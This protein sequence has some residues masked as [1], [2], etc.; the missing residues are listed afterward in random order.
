MLF[1]SS[2]PEQSKKRKNKVKQ[3]IRFILSHFK[4]PIFPRTISS[5]NTM[6]DATQFKVAY[7]EEEML[8]TYEQSKFIDCRV[9]IYRSSYAQE[10]PEDQRIADLIIFNVYK[11]IFMRES[12]QIKALY[13]ILDAIKKILA[14]IP[15]ILQ[16]RSSFHIYQPIE[17]HPLEQ[18]KQFIDHIIR[19]YPE[20][21]LI[22]KFPGQIF[23]SR[24][25][26]LLIPGTF[27]SNIE[28]RKKEDEEIMLIRKWDGYRPRMVS[29]VLDFLS[30]PYVKYDHQADSKAFLICK[31]CFWCASNL[32]T[33]K[34]ITKC[35]M[36]VNNALLN[37]IPISDKEVYE[38][39]S[40]QRSRIKMEPAEYCANAST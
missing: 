40:S 6:Y 34:V 33:K 11:P 29:P 8:R 18:I 5:R 14:G 15:T 1:L 10:C 4:E 2:H 39:D 28:K 26:M 31:W 24:P 37:S 17:P 20:L 12:V 19:Q 16:S 35:P 32:S 30:R 36:C 25:S 21:Q 27:D 23:D 7:S 9:S 38:I 3:N 13:V 22:L